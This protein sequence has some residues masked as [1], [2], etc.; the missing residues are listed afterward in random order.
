[1]APTS[2][3]KAGIGILMVDAAIELGFI[4]SMVRWLNTGASG[5]YEVQY[6]GSTF[7]LAS[8]PRNIMTNQGHTSNGAAGSAFVLVGLGS[9]V[10]LRLRSLRAYHTNKL[11]GFIYRSWLALTVLATF[12]TL[13]ALIYVNVVTTMHDGQTIDLDLASTLAPGERYPLNT[14]TPQNWFAAVL[15]LPLANASQIS[16]ISRWLRVMHGW[17]WNLIPLFIIEVVVCALVLLDARE[18]PRRNHPTQ[19]KKAGEIYHAV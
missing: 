4:S 14:W 8:E 16:D 6:Q 12:L 2:L 13:A 17:R 18:K 11:L 1:M 7:L 10:A 3:L 19:M 15:Q 5:P 9:I